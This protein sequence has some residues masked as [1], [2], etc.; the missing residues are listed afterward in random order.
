M[1]LNVFEND[2]V[3]VAA[4]KD[5]AS[6]TIHAACTSTVLAQEWEKVVVHADAPLPVAEVS[7]PAVSAHVRCV[8]ASLM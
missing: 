7:S 3:F 5:A 1:D 4:G 2:R 6:I 8:R